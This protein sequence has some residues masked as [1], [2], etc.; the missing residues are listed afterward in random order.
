MKFIYTGSGLQ[1]W[2]RESVGTLMHTS[3]KILTFTNFYHNIISNLY[4]LCVLTI[5]YTTVLNTTL[6]SVLFLNDYILG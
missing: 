6:S 1:S 2:Q 5:K 3:G 4:L